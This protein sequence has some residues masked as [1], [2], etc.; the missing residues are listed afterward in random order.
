MVSNGDALEI[1]P[2]QTGFESLGMRF[3]ILSHGSK[4]R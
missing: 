2:P 4:R 3:K 1:F